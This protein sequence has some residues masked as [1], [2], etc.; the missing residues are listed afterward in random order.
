MRR[1]RGQIF[2]FHF[3]PLVLFELE[4]VRIQILIKKDTAI[5]E[6]L[7]RVFK[8][9]QRAPCDKYGVLEREGENMRLWRSAGSSPRRLGKEFGVY[10]EGSIEARTEET[11]TEPSNACTH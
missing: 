7:Y 4:C 6:K 9:H 10:S 11:F 5:W 2:T 8:E 1:V 3:P